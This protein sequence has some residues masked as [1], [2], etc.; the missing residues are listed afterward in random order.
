MAEITPHRDRGGGQAGPRSRTTAAAIT[1]TL[2]S[3]TNGDTPVLTSRGVFVDGLRLRIR[4]SSISQ[5][6]TLPM[7]G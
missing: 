2:T 6:T 4:G 1:A 3:S 5:P 7:V